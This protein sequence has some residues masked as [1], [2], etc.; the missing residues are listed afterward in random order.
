M[1]T[2]SNGCRATSTG[3]TSIILSLHPHND[4]G[5]GGRRHRAG[6]DGGR[7]P[8]RGHAVRQWRAHRQC[9]HRHAGAQHVHARHRPEARLLRH[10]PDEGGVRIFEPDAHPR[11]PPVCRR[12]RLHRLF[13]LPPGCH[14]QGHEGDQQGQQAAMG[15]ALSA[16]RSGRC[17][18][19]LRGDH[20]HQL[21]VGQ[22][23][24]RLHPACR[25]RAQ[26]AA[27]PADR[28]QPGDPGDHRCR[29]PRTAL[30]AHP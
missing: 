26:P 17:R 10:Q 20:P 4:R 24:H 15:G 2:R 1:P 16:H 9:R 29:G 22:G 6:A 13:R 14:Q 8:R 3:A 27:Q 5:T 12:T 19:H 25:L 28:V 30:Q 7:G 18:A 23:R 21:A 11:A